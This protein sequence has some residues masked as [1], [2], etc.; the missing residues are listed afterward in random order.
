[1]NKEE[2][3]PYDPL[4]DCCIYR[5]KSNIGNIGMRDYTDISPMI[6]QVSDTEE[7][8]EIMKIAIAPDGKM[9]ISG[10]DQALIAHL[11]TEGISPVRGKI[12]LCG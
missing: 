8:P 5:S 3:I 11:K 4:F 12:D 9:I 6:K 7:P 10:N 1:M 2:V